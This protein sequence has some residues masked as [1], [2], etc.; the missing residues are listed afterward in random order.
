MLGQ[1]FPVS[2]GDR[3]FPSAQHWFKD[4]SGALD[5]GLGSLLQEV[6]VHIQRRVTEIKGLEHLTYE[7][8]GAG[9]V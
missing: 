2:L 8:K 6:K 5:P 9:T 4:E 7:D 1:M 3:Y